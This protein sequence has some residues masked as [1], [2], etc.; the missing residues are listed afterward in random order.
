MVS[1]AQI[2]QAEASEEVQSITGDCLSR[3]RGSQGKQNQEY[4]GYNHSSRNPG[5][6][7]VLQTALQVPTGQKMTQS[8]ETMRVP[9]HG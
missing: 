3:S 1:R 6:A 8:K 9:W 5:T 7:T 4:V 2:R